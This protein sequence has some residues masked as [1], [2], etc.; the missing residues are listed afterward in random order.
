MNKRLF[1]TFRI[2]VENNRLRGLKLNFQAK[3]PNFQTF[4]SLKVEKITGLR[5]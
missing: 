3:K 5:L 2:K 4:K 1:S